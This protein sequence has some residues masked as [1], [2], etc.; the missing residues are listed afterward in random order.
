MLAIAAPAYAD[1]WLPPE[2]ETYTS[3]D[4]HARV[5]IVP[6]PL[7]GAFPYFRDKAAG[8]EPAG[9]A[10]NSDQTRPMARLE[11][12]EAGGWRTVW[13]EPLVNDVAPV[14][15]LVANGGR[16]LVTFDNWHMVGVG[17]DVVVIYDAQGKLVRK[18]GLD[19]LLPPSYIPLLP[20]SV[21]SLWWS[22][23]HALAEEGD[24]L[25]LRVLEPGER[26]LGEEKPKTVP[27]RIRLSDA[28][29]LPL[30]GPDWARTRKVVEA[31]NAERKAKW[32]EARALRARP[33][34]VPEGDDPD[35]WRS[36]L[37]ELR[38]R[39]SDAS[40]H[41][42]RG[43]VVSPEELQG[44]DDS[45]FGTIVYLLGGYA[46][47]NPYRADHFIFVAPDSQALAEALIRRLSGM[48]SGALQGATIAF[49]GT[50][51]Q[52]R[53]VRAAATDS[54]AV[55]ELIDKAI[56]YPAGTLPEEPPEWFQ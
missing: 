55:V 35:A 45:E 4:G 21:S 47:D 49:V 22:G 9:Q 34:P 15:A 44:D 24:T 23:E 20:R 41:G 42:Y 8:K 48:E 50:P 51:E 31:M 56:P 13:T 16:Y 6:R 11:L 26:K 30:E 39:L 33:L 36:Y 7:D 14:K 25:I 27:V 2:V 5:T 19:D 10:A 38:D 18:F 37:V 54:G 17:D 32:E 29:V 3:A 52:G 12:Q 1:S 28:Q 43:D 46:G 53:Q 40:G